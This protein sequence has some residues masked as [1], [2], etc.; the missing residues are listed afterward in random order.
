MHTAADRSIEDPS[1]CIVLFSPDD[2]TKGR[3]SHRIR[4]PRSAEERT[5]AAY[6]GELAQGA[7]GALGHDKGR[8]P[9]G[10]RPSSARR[11][12]VSATEIEA[13]EV[14]DVELQTLRLH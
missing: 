11:S 8:V 9:R 4:N 14:R 3:P 1:S 7:Q 2:Q 13:V 10:A 6:G 5:A 12:F